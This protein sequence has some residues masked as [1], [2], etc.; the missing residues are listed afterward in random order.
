MKKLQLILLILIGAS[1]YANAQKL[2]FDAKYITVGVTSNEWP[3]QLYNNPNLRHLGKLPFSY[4][5]KDKVDAGEIVKHLN[6]ENIGR[7]V[8]DRLFQRDSQGLYVNELYNQALQNTIIEEL[9]VA[10]HDASAEKKDVLKKEISRQ[11]LKNNYIVIFQTVNKERRGKIKTKKY[12]QVFHVNIDDK[13][14]EQA[15]LNWQ[16]PAVYDQI[17]V[18]VTFIAEGKVRDE[19]IFDIAKKVPAF[20]IRGS[21]FNRTP[22]LARTIAQQGVKKK[23]RFYVY[24][25]KENKDGRIHAKKVCTARVTEVT[26]EA[27]RLFTISGRYASTKKGDIAVQRDRHKSSVSIMGQYSAGNDARYGGRLQYE[28]LLNFSRKGITRYFLADA[29]YNAYKK[30]MEN[31]WWDLNAEKQIQPRLNN[32]EF[33]LGYGIGINFLGRMELMP[34]LLAGYQFS[35]F[36]GSG[37]APTYWNH[38]LEKWDSLTDD[39]SGTAIKSGHAVIGYAGVKLN[40]N[41]WYPVQL[42]VGVDYN[43]TNS[44]SKK[45]KPVLQQHT[46]NRLNVY[47]GLRFHL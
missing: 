19:L 4:I 12:W 16:N 26:N 40:V 35:F 8:L 1:I 29:G 36:S 23:D 44:F 46:Q 15:F 10:L 18:P 31:I 7:T 34:Y 38:D 33:M 17:K 14:I 37:N 13:I 39:K 5:N 42:T 6:D 25:L 11:L 27:T 22:F 3:D 41:L 2:S 45:F 32:A 30:E 47:A 28:Y 9:E 20:A 43:V 21:V 24:R